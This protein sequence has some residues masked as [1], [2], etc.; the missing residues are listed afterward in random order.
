MSKIFATT[1]VIL[2]IGS[3][4]TTTALAEKHK[5]EHKS[6][7]HKHE[8]K[9][10]EQRPVEHKPVEQRQEQHQQPASAATP[11]PTPVPHHQKPAH[12]VPPAAANSNAASQRNEQPTRH[13]ATPN[14]PT[15]N[16]VNALKPGPI[17]P[18]SLPSVGPQPSI[19][20]TESATSM[21]PTGPP[22]HHVSPKPAR[23]SHH[24][25]AAPT[26]TSGFVTGLTNG[27]APASGRP[28]GQRPADNG[29]AASTQSATPGHQGQAAG[30]V[31][32]HPQGSPG[33][34]HHGD[35][36]GNDRDDY[37][38]RDRDDD[39][40]YR[41]SYAHRQHHGSRWVFAGST[42]YGW[43]SNYAA[44][45][46]GGYGYSY[47]AV[48]LAPQPVTVY[49]PTYLNAPQSVA[50]VPPAASVP[51]PPRRAIPPADVVNEM[52]LRE[53]QKLMLKAVNDL[54]DELAQSDTGTEWIHHL[55]LTS[56]ARTLAECD[57]SL[58][59]PARL[60]MQ[61]FADV[62]EEVARD[63]AFKS[64]SQLWGFNVLN[65]G[66]HVMATDPVVCQRHRVSSA[67]NAL[68]HSFDAWQSAD[69]W[70]TYLRLESLVSMDDTPPDLNVRI[71]EIETLVAKFDRI[72][73]E[74]RYKMIHEQPT[75]RATHIALRSYLNDL[76]NII[77]EPGPMPE[78]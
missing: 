73:A 63:E 17:D 35:D 34:G 24:D 30:Q 13:H 45:Y 69:R 44:P 15:T 33:V 50:S 1:F 66:L 41:G 43:T 32:N 40:D 51:A 12:A 47:S 39:R 7:E 70:Q 49:A 76:R 27:P 28:S 58:N 38:G 9:P 26:Q 53:L 25:H 8:H 42:G 22:M 46:G 68:S 4:V 36:R 21:K 6:A 67:A 3:T 5:A 11:V 31:G 14:R 29:H 61:G 65:I 75:F 60:R 72:Q 54:E 71:Q 19:A 37:R 59:E 23:Q 56:I 78:M 62:F 10:A 20:S 16:N 57:E 74:E 52:P 18:G 55:Q 2:L 77:T 48:P 64:V